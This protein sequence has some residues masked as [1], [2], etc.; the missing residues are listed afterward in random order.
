MLSEQVERR[1]AAGTYEVLILILL[2]HALRVLVNNIN[3]TDIYI[4]LI[5]I[6]LDHALRENNVQFYQCWN[7]KS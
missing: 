2:D 7:K 5:L 4:V 3:I 6:L 1:V